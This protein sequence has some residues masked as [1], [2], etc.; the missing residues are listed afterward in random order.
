MPTSLKRGWIDSRRH[1]QN[2]QVP[3]R[4]L[5]LHLFSILTLCCS[6]Y[7][8]KTGNGRWTRRVVQANDFPGTEFSH[9]ICPSCF[10][11]LY[12]EIYR[13]RKQV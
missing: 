3:K 12:P 2:L 7:R 1:S 10:R 8:L 4:P 13:L 6:C 5:Q 9:G 11:H